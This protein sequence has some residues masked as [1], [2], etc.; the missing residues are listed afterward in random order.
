MSA[1]IKEIKSSHKIEEIGCTRKELKEMLISSSLKKH[2]KYYD[3]F[4]LTNLSIQ[5]LQ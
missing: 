1:L 3:A 2:K 4:E 5:Y